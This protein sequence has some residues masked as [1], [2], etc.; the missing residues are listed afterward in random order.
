MRAVDAELASVRPEGLRYATYRLPDGVSFVHF[1]AVSTA[2]GRNPLM[3][4]AA[5]AKFQ[6]GIGERCEEAPV[7][8]ELEEVGS[9]GM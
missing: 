1:A 3:E 8:V 4:V 6:E 7:T 9:Y 2:D 5:F